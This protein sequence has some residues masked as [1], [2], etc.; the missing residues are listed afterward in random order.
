MCQRQ[1]YLVTYPDNGRTRKA[2]VL[3]VYEGLVFLQPI[4]LNTKGQPLGPHIMPLE[5]LTLCV[6]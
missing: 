3:F 1:N 4:G 6:D 2:S 5:R